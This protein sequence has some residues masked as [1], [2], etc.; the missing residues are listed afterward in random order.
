[1]LATVDMAFHKAFME[2]LV[3]KPV[4]RTSD[5]IQAAWELAKED[6]QKIIVEIRIIKVA[7][8]FTEWEQ[9]NNMGKF[10]VRLRKLRD[11]IGNQDNQFY[12]ENYYLGE[13]Y[14]NISSIISPKAI[15]MPAVIYWGQWIYGAQLT[16]NGVN[17]P[18]E[19]LLSRQPSPLYTIRNGA[20]D[21]IPNKREIMKLEECCLFRAPPGSNVAKSGLAFPQAAIAR[22]E[23]TKTMFIKLINALKAEKNDKVVV[24]RQDIDPQGVNFHPLLLRTPGALGIFSSSM[25]K[26]QRIER[27]VKAIKKLDSCIQALTRATAETI[28]ISI[29][30]AGTN[31]SDAQFNTILVQ[32]P[33][34]INNID[35]TCGTSLWVEIE[36]VFPTNGIFIEANKTNELGEET[37]EEE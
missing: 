24:L 5:A 30:Q 29:R 18:L 6:A 14:W 2:I 25:V 33:Q 37:S 11:S 22:V 28:T 16:E 17:G 1:M 8:C 32:I 19:A 20:E 15:D 9:T 34:S 35:E 4:P 31:T 10:G 3:Q 36:N 27:I 7:R 21:V 12:E 13:N 26:S 23:I